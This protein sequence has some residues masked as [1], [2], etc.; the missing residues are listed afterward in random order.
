MDAAWLNAL[1][2]NIIAL[3]LDINVCEVQSAQQAGNAQ[4]RGLVGVG[5]DSPSRFDCTLN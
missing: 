2:L 3:C 1:G 4:D 5:F